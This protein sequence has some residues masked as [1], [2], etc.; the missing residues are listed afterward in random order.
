MN[1]SANEWLI[2]L[3]SVGACILLVMLFVRHLETRVNKVDTKLHK[4]EERIS[5]L[6]V[7][8]YNQDARLDAHRKVLIQVKKDVRSLGKDIG[9]DDSNRSTQVMDAKS[10]SNLVELSR[11]KPPDDEP[12]PDAA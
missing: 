9:W 12:P 10:M 6:E 5:V 8:D 11:K 4:D 3:G 1:E 2:V 7:K